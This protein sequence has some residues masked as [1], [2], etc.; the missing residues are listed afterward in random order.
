[1]TDYPAK[2]GLYIDGEWLS[3]GGR[4]AHLVLNPATGATQADLPLA[5]T[6]DLD[7]ALD[8]ADRG[9]REW[10]GGAPEA[11]AAILPTAAALIRARA[12]HNAHILTMEQGKPLA[13]AKG[14]V[15]A[16]AGLI[17]FHAAEGM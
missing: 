1:M 14:E 10:R 17:D 2:L 7:R 5:T 6:A 3:G 11:R 13:A 12:D 9:F 15:V 16:S 4:D 8:A